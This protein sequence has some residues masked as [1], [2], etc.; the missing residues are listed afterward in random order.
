MEKLLPETHKTRQPAESSVGPVL[1][2]KHVWQSE[3]ARPAAKLL[4]LNMNRS[5]KTQSIQSAV[6]HTDEVLSCGTVSR[7]IVRRT[8]V[9]LQTRL[10][11]RKNSP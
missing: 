9:G 1:G 4:E 11:A 3:K 6:S 7:G 2:C 5:E 10:A 8:G